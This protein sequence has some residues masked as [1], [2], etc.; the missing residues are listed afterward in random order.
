EGRLPRDDALLASDVDAELCGDLGMDSDHDP[1]LAEP[2]DGLVE[3]NAPPFDL[4]SVAI[5]EVS[6]V[7]GGDGAEQLAFLGGLFP[8][9]EYEG[10]DPLAETVG[11]GLDAPGLSLLLLLDVIE[12]LEVTGGGGESQLLGNQEVAG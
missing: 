12:P 7:L 9:L 10:L 5:E 4:Q 3:V 1:A 6:D 2:L 8:D 11:V